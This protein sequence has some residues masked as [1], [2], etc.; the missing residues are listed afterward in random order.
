MLCLLS[1]SMPLLASQPP[2]LSGMLTR[3]PFQS[4][5]SSMSPSVFL[6]IENVGKA[7]Q[8]AIGAVSFTFYH[9]AGLCRR[10]SWCCTCSSRSP[11]SSLGATPP[12]QH[13]PRSRDRTVS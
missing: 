9:M 12:G 13:L 4:P 10:R 2:Y 8:S 5:W 11:L 6:G 7:V 3:V 1:S